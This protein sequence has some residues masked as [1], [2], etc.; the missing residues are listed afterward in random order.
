MVHKNGK[1]SI[2][3]IAHPKR[4]EPTQNDATNFPVDDVAKDGW[5]YD[6][7]ANNETSDSITV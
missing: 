5:T 3:L 1:L 4:T 7:S 6:A 2:K